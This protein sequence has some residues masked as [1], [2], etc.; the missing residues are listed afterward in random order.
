[1]GFLANF[2]CNK[3]SISFGTT[4]HEKIIC[5]IGI[6]QKTEYYFHSRNGKGDSIVPRLSLMS[7]LSGSCILDIDQGF[8]WICLV[9]VS[10]QRSGRIRVRLEFAAGLVVWVFLVFAWVLQTECFRRFGT[11]FWVGSLSA[12][13]CFVGCFG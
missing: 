2:S 5:L 8:L 3:R 9:G 4:Y 12:M 6:C 10:T 13:A 7:N 1:M 11:A